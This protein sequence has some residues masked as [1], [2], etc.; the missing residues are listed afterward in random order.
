[1][2]FVSLIIA[3]AAAEAIGSEETAADYSAL[4]SFADQQV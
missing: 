1:M 2:S 3:S 4:E